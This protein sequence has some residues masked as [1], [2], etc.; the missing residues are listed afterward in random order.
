MGIAPPLKLWERG[1][2]NQRR[3]RDEYAMRTGPDTRLTPS[4]SRASLVRAAPT[5]HAPSRTH[6]MQSPPT[7]PFTGL[8][9]IFPWSI[10]STRSRFSV[11]PAIGSSGSRPPGYLSITTTSR[12]SSGKSQGQRYVQTWHGTP[13]KKLARH[14]PSRYLSASYPMLMEREARDVGRPARTKRVCGRR[15]TRGLWV[16]GRG[17]DA[18]LPTQRCSGCAGL[19]QCRSVNESGR[20]WG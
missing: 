3:L 16:R 12:R 19:W 2:Y 8:S 15:P 14:A 5:V 9:T 6:C 17:P 4:S 11:A 1:K 10:P 13:L 18:R 7:C 20:I